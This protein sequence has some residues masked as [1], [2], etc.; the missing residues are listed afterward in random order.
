MYVRSRLD[1]TPIAADL[2]LIHIGASRP[3][4]VLVL[5]QATGRHQLIGRLAAAI[6]YELI[7]ASAVDLAA[8]TLARFYLPRTGG[9]RPSLAC[10]LAVLRSARR[11]DP[12]APML[13]Q[14]SV[15]GDAPVVEPSKRRPTTRHRLATARRFAS[16]R[17]R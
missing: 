12:V 2:R 3:Q 9:K 11:K 16:A 1:G 14:G 7:D 13:S 15:N 5:Q 17:I 6:G 10:L 4:F 8:L